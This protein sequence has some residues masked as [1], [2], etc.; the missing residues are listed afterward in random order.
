[1][2]HAFG[3]IA[4]T[5]TVKALQETSGSRANYARMAAQTDP[6]EVR[7][8]DSE[9]AFIGAR[10]SFYMATVGETGWPHVQHRGGPAGFVRTL[11]AQTIGFA[12]FVGNRQY[13]SVGN[14]TTDDRVSLFFMD[15]PNRRRLKLL[16]HV[17]LIDP[18]AEPDLLERLAVP[19]YKARVQ[20]GFAI[21]VAAFDWNCPQHITPRYTEADV[22][23][24]VSS[25]TA[26]IAELE[27]RL[28]SG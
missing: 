1:M 22:S 13:V 10:D 6:A 27:A 28:A 15:Y 7:L 5:P 8:T 9:A 11:D 21:K 14:L 18:A 25:L 2:G 4:F 17:R 26:R 20:R 12:D 3:D 19:G 24:A 16:G 23:Q